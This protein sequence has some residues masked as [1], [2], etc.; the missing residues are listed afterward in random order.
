MTDRQEFTYPSS[1]GVHQVHAVLWLPQGAPRGVVQLVHG[2]C[3][4]ALRYDPFARFLA[5]H[6]FAVA[7]ND[8]Q[9]RGHSAKGPV[10]P[11]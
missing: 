3:E 7:G 9:G 2:I 4:Y 1:D 11:G 5:E 6:G 10:E 8:R